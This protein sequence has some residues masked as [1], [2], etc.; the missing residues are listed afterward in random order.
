MHTASD[1]NVDTQ[2]AR[3][4]DEEWSTF[5]QDEMN[6]PR[7]QREAIFESYFRIFPPGGGR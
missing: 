1:K 6:L 4:F 5:R 2:V 3:G 7:G